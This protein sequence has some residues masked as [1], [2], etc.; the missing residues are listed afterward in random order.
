VLFV[1]YVV[2]AVR[3]FFAWRA[4][5]ARHEGRMAARAHA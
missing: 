3:G 2:I 1:V 5:L 4:D